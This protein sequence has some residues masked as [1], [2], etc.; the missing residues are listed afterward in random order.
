MVIAALPVLMTVSHRACCATVMAVS[1]KVF[2]KVCPDNCTPEYCFH[3]SC[4]HHRQLTDDCIAVGTSPDHKP[5]PDLSSGMVAVIV[6]MTVVGVAVV[7]FAAKFVIGRQRL[8]AR[9]GGY[10]SNSRTELED[11]DRSDNGSEL[12]RHTPQVRVG[13]WF[14]S[15]IEAHDGSLRFG[16][17]NAANP[18]SKQHSSSL[19]DP[20]DLIDFSGAMTD[21]DLVDFATRRS[22]A[23][24]DASSTRRD[25]AP[26][27]RLSL[28]GT[29][30]QAE[31]RTPDRST[32][33]SR[34]S[35]RAART[36]SPDEVKSGVAGGGR[37]S[38]VRGFA[39]TFLSRSR[40]GSDTGSHGS[41]LSARRSTSESPVDVLT[42]AGII[43]DT[44]VEIADFSLPTAEQ[45]RLDNRRSS[46]AHSTVSQP[47][48]REQSRSSSGHSGNNEA[49]TL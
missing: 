32:T 12:H 24:S 49:Y 29:S 35:L 16:S 20:N 5:A 43:D 36:P 17:D 14:D 9:Q 25:N 2:V 15:M 6:V 10:R 45:L 4:R 41:V 38:A 28:G 18:S 33:G 19:N 13:G 34:F 44:D 8:R 46:D 48:S 23:N 11:L 30:A 40:S 37:F 26:V 21:T 42:A 31:C 22:R 3:V 47:R 1:F 7:A 27:P 39:A